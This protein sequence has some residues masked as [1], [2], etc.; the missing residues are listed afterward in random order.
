[1][2]KSVQ[3]FNVRGAGGK[4]YE[5]LPEQNAQ[6]IQQVNTALVVK[7]GWEHDPG[8]I[9]SFVDGTRTFTITPDNDY[10]EYWIQG[11]K[12]RIESAESVILDDTEG[13][14][15]VYYVGI[16]LTAS[17]TP[18]CIR[19]GDKAFVGIFYWDATNNV[20]L[21]CGYECHSFDMA[22][23]TH[24][25]LHNTLGARFECGLALVE[26]T[27]G[28]DGKI[29][30]DGG[31]LHDEDVHIEIVDG[32]G[33][34]QFEQELGNTSVFAPAQIPVFYRLGASAW[35]KYTATDY[36]FYD[37]GAVDN[38]HYNSYSAP[39]WSSTEA[40]NTA[41]YI[42]MWIFGTN[43]ICT[44]VVAIMGQIE[45]LTL[46]TA[47]EANTLES[48]NFGSLPFQEMKILYRLIFKSDSSWAHTEDMRAVA[49]VPGGTY[50]PSPTP[51]LAA[52]A[53]VGSEL[54][55]GQ[56]ITSADEDL[57]FTFGRNTLGQTEND[58]ATF[59]YRGFTITDF[60]IKQNN[61]YSTILN[62]ADTKTIGFR[63]NNV[64]KATLSATALTMSVPIAM[65][66]F[67]ITLNAGSTVD[68][69]DVSAISITSMP[70]AVNNWKLFC[71]NGSGI[72]TELATG[73]ANTVLTGNGVAVAPSFQAAAFIPPI[74]F[75]TMFSGAFTNN[76]TIPGWYKCDGNNGTVNLV[77]KFV[78]GGSASGA[79]GGSDDAVVVS[80]LH[81]MYYNGGTGAFEAFD[82]GAVIN[83]AYSRNTGLTGVSGVGLNKPAYYTLIFI[84]RIS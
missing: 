1:M 16:T 21:Y 7:T 57:T 46:A 53:A 8:V 78:R 50:V 14:W 58:A 54:S 84:Q 72:M 25:Y 32:A 23:V 26:G 67:N 64:V 43:D 22:P 83:K 60:A 47:K 13:I 5:Y 68:G 74:G 71:T 69:V 4:T 75:I 70:T 55:S 45:S 48:I 35:R 52:V 6:R 79:T 36:P 37:N 30:M 42:A 65:G 9:F 29:A 11:V 80:H 82:C 12:Y 39:N 76:I 17:Q 10:F 77:D 33:S 81:K 28:D 49:N 56:V 27:A 51:T 61:V 31:E 18:W 62:A 19:D 20:H 41:K 34:G 15:Y 59:G 66:A 44:P 2:P 24:E 63:I 40:A 73:A 3:D 38:V